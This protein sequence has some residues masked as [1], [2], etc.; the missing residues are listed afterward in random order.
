MNGY[1][2]GIARFGPPRSWSPV[3]AESEDR[4][5]DGGSQA[6]PGLRGRWGL[7]NHRVAVAWGRSPGPGG[8]GIA[9]RE[10]AGTERQTGICAPG[11]AG[12]RGHESLE[13]VGF[14]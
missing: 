11:A 7:R 13:P 9:N 3:Q 12:S 10:D 1:T 4:D 5:D 8:T 6:T 14:R 2:S